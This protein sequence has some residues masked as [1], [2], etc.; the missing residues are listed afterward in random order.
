MIG[1]AFFLQP[2]IARIEA[3]ARSV[4]KGPVFGNEGAPTPELRKAGLTE[5]SLHKNKK[6]L[7]KIFCYMSL[8]KT[9]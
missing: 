9:I 3:A 1:A 2:N 7:I 5:N 8:S 6:T 4:P